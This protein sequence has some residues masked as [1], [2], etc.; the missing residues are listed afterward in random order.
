MTQD[1]VSQGLTP[2]PDDFS[3]VLCIVAHPDDLEYGA[4]AAVARWTDEGKHVSYF[5]LT[6]GEAG[7]DTLSP[8]ESA[9]VR[10][11]EQ[12]EAC[13]RVGVQDLDF[14]THRDGVIEYSLDLRR[15]IAR[16]IRRRRPDVVVTMA[17]TERFAGGML[18]QADHRAVGLAAI[19]AIAD[20]GNR[21]VFPELLQEGDDPWGGVR[22]IAVTASLTPTHYVDVT[23]FLQQAVASLE[24]HEQYLSVLSS[25]YP[26]PADLICGILSSGG[27]AAGCQHALLLEV[28][29]R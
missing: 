20:A 6:R 10:S 25:D 17:H 15:D 14:G 7:I 4:S 22:S 2:L 19:D 18:N 23:G 13:R 11:A 29:E 24:A 27:E 3:R 16:Q 9:H 26:K 8:T 12:A 21:W 5:L 28:I 1:R